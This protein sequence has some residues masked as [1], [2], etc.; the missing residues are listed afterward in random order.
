MAVHSP[1]LFAERAARGRRLM[2]LVGYFFARKRSI[3][4][5]S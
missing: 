4:L 3:N 1:E 5:V 2:F